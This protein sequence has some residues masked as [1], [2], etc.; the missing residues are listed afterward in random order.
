MLERREF[1]AASLPFL[2]ARR[3]T[4]AGR[5]DL[6]AIERP[7]VL[8]AADA[9]LKQPPIT[10]TAFHTVRSAGGPHDYFSEADYWWPDSQNPGGPYIQR[11]GM[12]NPDN[13]VA[14]RRALMRLSVQLPAL[15]AAWVLTKQHA[16]A[17]HA[18]DHL[19]AWFL[20]E[21][22]LMNPNLAY[23]QAIHGR[24]TIGRASCRERV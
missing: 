2:L 17:G 18:A 1:L 20:D 3:L 23:A 7:R 13:F 10:I 5:F 11:D 24:A 8:K 21:R 22:T 15:C 19:R 12:S 14:H 16:Y 9:Y 4:P 6:A